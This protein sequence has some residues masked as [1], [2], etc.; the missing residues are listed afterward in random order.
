[1]NIR[2]NFWLSLYRRLSG[3]YPYEFRMLYGE[4]LDRLGEDAVPEVSRRY[5]LPGL[6]RLL[7]DMAV[8]LP[9]MYLREVRQDVV[10]ALRMLAKSPGFAALAV[11]SLAIG[12]GMCCAVLSESEAL[13]GPPPGVR[14]PAALVTIRYALVSYPYFERYRDQRQTTVSGTALLPMVPFA[15]SFS[16]D[17]GGK[18]E[19][20]FGHLVSPEYFSTLGVTA[21]A[22]RLFAPETERLGM[23]PVVVVSER[24]WRM[25]LGQDPHAVGRTLR[26]NGRMATI[27]GI[28]PKD[29]LGVWPGNPADL[30]VPV[31]CGASL[32][33]EL[34]GDP[35]NRRDHEIFRV[36][37]R[38]A[39]GVTIPMA[40]AA[41]DGATRRLDQENGLQLNRDRKG[42]VFRLMPAGTVMNITP[43]QRGFVS[44]FN[45]VLWALVLSL[46]C[47]NLGNLLLARGSQRRREIAVRL[48]V[49]A[50]RARLVRQLLTESVLLSLA[51]GLAGIMLAWW[52]TR[53]MSSL[54]VP[55]PFPLE[56]HCQ[57]DFRV[58]ALTL[59][60]ALA[61]GIGFGL[62]PA[63]ASLHVDIGRTLKEGAQTALRGYG[64][65]GLRN[66]FVVGQ[67]AASLM[68]LLVTWYTVT[69]FLQT[70]RIDPG[71][72]L[73]NLNLVSLDPVRD[74]YSAADAAALF[75]N[76]PE[77][78][79]RVHGVRAVSLVDSLPFAIMAASQSNTRVSTAAP[80]DPRGQV[81]HAI[82]RRSVGAGYF[83]AMGTP[84]V[85]GR[86]FDRR[87]QVQDGPEPE[88]AAAV[89][90]ILNQT[91]A[92]E[93]FGLEDPI[94]RPIRE[95]E[96][97]YTVIGL[98]RDT[99]HGFLMSKPVPTMFV[100]LTSVWFRKNPAQP[101]TLLV[102]GTPGRDTLIAVRNQLAS[103][104]PNLTVFNAR[105]MR[106][107]LDRL[108]TWV[109]WDAAIYEALGVFAL[110][111]AC[112]G[113]AGVTAYA[114]VRRRK[115]IGIRMALGARSRQ[116]Q[117]LVL[118]E[119]MALVAVGTAL[120][121]G[122][123]FALLRALSAY[124]EMLARSFGKP[125]DHSL[126][127]LVAPL[128]L[129]G[130]AMLACYLPA[131]RATGIDPMAALREE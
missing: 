53:V 73:A 122:G 71:S 82:F 124:S 120:G 36:V 74:G 107:D 25:H 62:A 32:A 15:V 70:G 60:I 100:P 8:Q 106:E 84:M 111:L 31:T 92:H 113:L 64:R 4:D 7:A 79:G 98:A 69:S 77:Q 126:L 99:Q 27:V 14:D 3:A 12:I 88:G 80:G 49:G 57:P 20:F 87:D 86:E 19:R 117:R 24:F 2:L 13:V 66:L 34:S 38:L 44:T 35:L 1:M 94:G 63:L 114:V 26:L 68:L 42:R 33:P 123:A 55:S 128:T 41:L 51:G 16:G 91:A 130:L 105:T 116:V 67:M 90:A 76:L 118:R 17:K 78:L 83:A 97:N 43:E 9:V 56:F 10:Y 37:L 46:V 89:P 39:P 54:T 119:G 129:A 96:R 11:L 30:F 45:V 93:L 59:A 110:F 103:I 127:I 23:P 121:L 47:A 22:G 125:A 5:G 109:Q 108:N 65:F 75:A 85:G 112:I 6:L 101:A 40:E 72:E 115:E 28:G 61:A 18:A 48:S 21:A 81:L 102:R 29:F 52:I 95:G 50:G 58:L 131:R 104:H